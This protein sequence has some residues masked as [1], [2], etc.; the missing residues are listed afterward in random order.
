MGKK[1]KLAGKDSHVDH[2]RE[3]TKEDLEERMLARGVGLSMLI[4]NM[5][6][7]HS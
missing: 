7:E 3:T 4:D 1:V 5:D 6:V 2:H